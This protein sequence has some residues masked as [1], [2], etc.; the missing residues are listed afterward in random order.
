MCMARCAGSIRVENAFP[1]V[2]TA[3]VW[4]LSRQGRGAGK[5]QANGT[6]RWSTRRS[7]QRGKRSKKVMR[8][9]AGW[10][11]QHRKTPHGNNYNNNNKWS[12]G[13]RKHTGLSRPDNA[14]GTYPA[15]IPS[16]CYRKWLTARGGTGGGGKRGPTRTS[17]KEETLE[18]RGGG[19]RQ[20]ILKDAVPPTRRK[21]EASRG[22]VGPKARRIRVGRVRGPGPALAP[23]TPPTPVYALGNVTFRPGARTL[24]IPP[25]DTSGT[26]GSI[27]L[28]SLTRFFL[29]G[30]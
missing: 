21:G 14:A 16:R 27:L 3:I 19:G 7:G 28:P 5:H 13:V 30:G 2:P 12:R 26:N 9:N 20:E 24:P 4:S 25:I 11:N 1:S 17:D 23:L 6:I 22:V 15:G 29:M 8:D 18:G 10:R